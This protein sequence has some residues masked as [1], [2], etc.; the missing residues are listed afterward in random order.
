MKL[1]LN[2]I[3]SECLGVYNPVVSQR[4]ATMD[5]N[6]GLWKAIEWREE[7]RESYI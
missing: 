4:V 1:C 2:P 5:L 3:G 6:E 7:R